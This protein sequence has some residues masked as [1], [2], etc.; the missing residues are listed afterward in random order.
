MSEVFLDA[1][2]DTL[3]VLPFLLLI[4][5]LIELL[6]HKTAVFTNSKILRGHFAPV[7]GAAAGI[8]PL[9]GFSVMAAKLYDKRYIRTGTL[10]SVFI[11]TSDEAIIVL[12]SEFDL[13]MLYAVLPL[14]AVQFLLAVAVGYAANAILGKREAAPPQP[15]AAEEKYL[16]AHEHSHKSP[17]HIYFLNPLRHALK[18]ALYLFIVTFAFGG[19]I[20][21][22]GEDKILNALAVNAYVQPLITSAVGLI[23][24]C[25]ASVIIATSYAHGVIAFGSMVSGLIINAGMGFVVLVKNPKNIGRT[26]AIAAVLYVIAYLAGIGLNALAPYMHL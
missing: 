1:L 10:L 8:I 20:F 22:V 26:V 14:I 13:N 5:M 15:A 21:L 24:S 9:C 16:C 19:L 4:Y 18:I 6:E 7:L 25:A 17:L 11:A 23:P 12:L 2:L 3:K